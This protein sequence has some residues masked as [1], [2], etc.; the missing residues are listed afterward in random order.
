MKLL[1]IFITSVL[2]SAVHAQSTISSTDRYTFAANAGWLDFRA[3]SANGVRVRDTSLAGNVYAA[4]VGWINLGGGS[5]SNGHSYTNSSA[6][7]FGVNVAADGKLTGFAYGANIGWINFEQTHGQAQIDL[8][9][10]KFSGSAYSANI[11]WISLDTAFS[12][13][14]TDGISRSD[15]DGDGI[16]DAW[17][18]LQFGNLTMASATSDRDSDGASDLNEYNSGTLPNDASSNLRIVSHNYASAFTS[19]SISFTT[20]ATRNYRIE[21]DEDLVGT[22]TNSSLGTISPTGT[23]TAGNLVSLSPAPRRFFRVIAVPLPSAF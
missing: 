10:G 19:A 17:E 3:D 8:R 18:Q 4:N 1:S 21:F 7:D 11:G 2:C 6:T 12:D 20:V 23:I 9:T 14:A 22:W 16:A 5:P 15:N 13:L